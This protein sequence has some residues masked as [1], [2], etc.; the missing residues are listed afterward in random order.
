MDVLLSR[1]KKIPTKYHFNMYFHCMLIIYCQLY[2]FYH[3]NAI[4][5]LCSPT[6]CIYDVSCCGSLYPICYIY[7]RRLY[8]FKCN[9]SGVNS[10]HV[11]YFHCVDVYKFTFSSSTVLWFR[12]ATI[13]N[14]YCNRHP[15][16][17]GGKISWIRNWLILFRSN[18]II[19]WYNKYL[20]IYI[21][22]FRLDE[23]KL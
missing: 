9:C 4:W 8:N 19:Y 18:A 22:T 10:S 14:I 17:S 13:W 2:L 23:F 15:V 16:D 5:K 11:L 20:L 21:A 3:W 1:R 7:K 12:S 6:S